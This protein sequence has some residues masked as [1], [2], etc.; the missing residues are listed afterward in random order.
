MY[1]HLNHADQKQDYES[2][3]KIDKY[4]K[5]LKNNNPRIVDELQRTPLLILLIF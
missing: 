4:L 3:L 1:R 2:L 5:K